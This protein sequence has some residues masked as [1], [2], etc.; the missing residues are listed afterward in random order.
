MHRRIHRCT[1]PYYK[2]IV[3]L[4]CFALQ[5]LLRR[6]LMYEDSIRWAR[7][8]AE[9]MKTASVMCP[10]SPRAAYAEIVSRLQARSHTSP[11]LSFVLFK[12]HLTW[13]HRRLGPEQA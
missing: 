11:A 1:G 8:L 6:V 12:W 2:Y 13:L 4:T 3:T 9:V 7:C 10:A 5:D